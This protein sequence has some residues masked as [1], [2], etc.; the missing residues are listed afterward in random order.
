[1]VCAKRRTRV[2]RASTSEAA[3]LRSEYTKKTAHTPED[4]GND[5][6][7]SHDSNFDLV[8]TACATGLGS[9]PSRSVLSTPGASSGSSDHDRDGS[10]ENSTD[11]A[12]G[13]PQNI[14]DGQEGWELGADDEQ[15]E[16][17]TGTQAEEHA[18][19][20]FKRAHNPFSIPDAEPEDSCWEDIT[21]SSMPLLPA[22][23]SK[24]A[25]NSSEGIDTSPA[26]REWARQRRELGEESKALDLLMSMVGLEEVK[27]EF[28]AIKATITAAKHRKGILRRQ[29]FNL[30]TL[31][32]IYKDFLAECGIWSTGAD[33]T[34]RSGLEFQSDRAVDSLRYYLES[35]LP[36]RPVRQRIGTFLAGR[37]SGRWLFPRRLELPDYDD[38]QLHTILLQL[39]HHNSFTAE[40]GDTGPYTRIVA[41]RVGKGR[42]CSGFT[43]IVRRQ[44]VRLENNG[45][46]G[47]EEERNDPTGSGTTATATTD[48]SLLTREDL[49]GQEPEDIRSRSAA[50]KELEKMAGLESRREI[51]GKE[52]LQTSLNRVFM[53]PPGT[54]KTTVAKL[55]AHV[56]AEIGLLS[57]RD[58][59]Y[60]TPDDFIGQYIG[61]SEVKTREILGST[62]GKVLIIDDA[63]MFY[64][65]SRGGYGFTTDTYRLGCIDT[66]VFRI[67]NRPGEDRCV[68]LLGYADMM[69][70]M[71]EKVNPGLRRRFP[72]EEAFRFEDYDDEH[73]D[74][75]LRLKMAQEEICATD[76]A[77]EVA[78]E[79]LRLA[80]DRPNFGNG[81]DVDNLLN[82]AKT[83]ALFADLIGFSPIL[84]TFRGY[85]RM[86]AN[87]RR[88]GK[89]PRD[90]IP[91]TFVFKGPLGTGKTHTARIVGQ[92]FYDK[93]FLSTS[94][95]V[96]CS[97]SQ[98]LGEYMGQSAPKVVNLFER[99]LG[100]VL[101]IDE[102]YRLAGG[103]AP[104]GGGCHG[105]E[106][107]AVG[108]LVDCLTKNR[109]LKKVVVVLAG[110][111]RDMDRLMR[112]NPGLKG[113]FA[114]D[115]CFPPMD[116]ARMREHLLSLLKKEDIEVRDVVGE[117]A[118]EAERMG[119]SN[120][121][122]IRTLAA[123][124][125]GEVHK[126]AALEDLEDQDEGST[127][128]VTTAEL[129][130][131]LED[132]LEQRMRAGDMM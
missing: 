89:D 48:H 33:Y 80:R 14:H 44:A 11:A 93:G 42:G 117:V 97:A 75:I 112:V 19:P 109:Y 128:G 3:D 81:G 121:R 1:M 12:G 51:L 114:T 108:E 24:L 87:F 59:V 88:R 37:P 47:L 46:S 38:K 49:I 5:A 28:L 21:H 100:E 15:P 74:Q 53:G 124:I 131:F 120:A 71:F 31:A 58:V 25:L 132:M 41:K 27:R 129:N 13:A 17:E 77:M 2:T 106:E 111:D 29:E 85:Q 78:A 10:D 67:H 69:E 110:Y 63:P 35:S 84:D 57:T 72:L 113:R 34:A 54:G 8:E 52:P 91:F 101:F 30:R 119:W 96:Q 105:Y 122:D 56:L 45:N 116:A 86:A 126:A 40:S 26:E 98:L 65:G 22:L 94:E 82:Q 83:R 76:Q 60:K 103:A 104:S 95:V 36:G 70:D 92:I 50:W 64:H 4:G 118:E 20:E 123:V 7:K 90:I 39:I 68:I 125:T 102:A 73:L 107:E 130:G 115:V 23:G 79:V 66:I 32:T 6:G 61:E 16:H 9:P 62:I 18:Q 55:Y 99:A 43:N 127:F